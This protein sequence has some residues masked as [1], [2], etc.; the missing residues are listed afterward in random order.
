M[1]YLLQFGLAHNKNKLLPQRQINYNKIRLC[2]A[3]GAECGERRRRRSQ[4]Y[5]ATG[6]ARR[7]AGNPVAGGDVRQRPHGRAL[8][9]HATVRRH[10][11][12]QRAIRGS[13]VRVRATVH[14]Q[15]VLH[16]PHSVRTV[17]HQAGSERSVLR[18]HGGRPV[19]Q[20][21][22]GSVGRGQEVAVRMVQR[23]RENRV[24]TANGYRRPGRHTVGL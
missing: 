19:R 23:L 24:Q 9:V 13:E 7:H 3:V 1:I 21:P 11:L 4:R 12:V 17:R 6:T 14:R 10:R 20:G 22:T 8:A 15:N 18:E 2:F 16:V 5:L